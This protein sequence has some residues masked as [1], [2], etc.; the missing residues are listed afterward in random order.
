MNTIHDQISRDPVDMNAVRVGK[1]KGV[2]TTRLKPLHPSLYHS[3]IAPPI[4][5]EWH[6][7]YHS[8]STGD[9]TGIK[10][11][12]LTVVGMVKME[13]TELS[14]DKKTGGRWAV[15]CACGFYEMRTAKAVKNPKNSE[16]ACQDCK[17]LENAKRHHH[18]FVSDPK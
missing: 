3:H 9:L 8:Q 5:S 14:P 12:R 13:Q 6:A 7:K 1:F 4:R 18:L 17:S 16:D 10:F 15:R 11:G 2:K